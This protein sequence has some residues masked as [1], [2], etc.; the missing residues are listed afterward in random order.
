MSRARRHSVE[1]MTPVQRLAETLLLALAVPSAARS[2]EFNEIAEWLASDL[3]EA[4]I[5]CAKAIARARW[6]AG[7]AP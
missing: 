2:E 4:E 3:S 7:A 1:A 5:E 6:T